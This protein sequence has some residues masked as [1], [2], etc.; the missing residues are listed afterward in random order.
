MRNNQN[1]REP[2]ESLFPS[3]V[4]P[5]LTPTAT[6]PTA[7]PFWKSKTIF[8]GRTNSLGKSSVRSLVKNLQEKSKK[9][10]YN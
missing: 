4:S 6:G 7:F 3:C 1:R 8:F 10:P 5:D 9:L 2:S